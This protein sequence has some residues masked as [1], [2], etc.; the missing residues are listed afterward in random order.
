MREG[1][2]GGRDGDRKVGIKGGREKSLILRKRE[3]EQYG[4]VRE[5]GMD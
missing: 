4:E 3:W 2:K 1:K 5:R